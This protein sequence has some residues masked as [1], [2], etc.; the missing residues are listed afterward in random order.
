MNIGVPSPV[1]SSAGNRR[2]LFP[3]DLS[4]IDPATAIIFTTP[5]CLCTVTFSIDGLAQLVDR[6]KVISSHEVE[7][8]L[9]L[10]HIN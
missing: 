3:I 9:S 8:S 2:L 7:G 6:P 10:L 5:G 4:N 1:S